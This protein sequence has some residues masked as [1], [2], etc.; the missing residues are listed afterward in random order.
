[1]SYGLKTIAIGDASQRLASYPQASIKAV[2]CDGVVERIARQDLANFLA[3]CARILTSFGLIR[4]I[5]VDL[6]QVVHG[7]LFNW[8]RSEG[9][10]LS[11][12]ER[13]N[14][15]FRGP[16]ICFLYGE[17]ELSAALTEAGFREIRRFGLGGS[18]YPPFCNLPVD[19][20]Q[21]LILEAK[22]P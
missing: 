4:L 9:V 16:G 10:G 14:R 12:T 11:R 2:L 7:Y 1:V 13:L 19:V 15:A 17:E 22:K 8:G 3:L 18:S 5:T 20:S 21:G 6:D